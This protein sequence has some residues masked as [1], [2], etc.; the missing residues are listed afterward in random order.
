[1]AAVK[2]TIGD[3]TNLLTSLL[4]VA[5]GVTGIMVARYKGT[6]FLKGMLWVIGLAAAGAGAGYGLSKI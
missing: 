6:G 1:M 4:G 3:K 5:G 2:V